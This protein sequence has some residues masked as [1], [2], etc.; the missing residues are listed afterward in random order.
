MGHQIE[1]FASVPE[2]AVR[3]WLDRLNGFY[4]SDPGEVPFSWEGDLRSGGAFWAHMTPKACNFSLA[5]NYS[6]L[7]HSDA[8]TVEAARQ[9]ETEFWAEFGPIPLLRVDEYMVGEWYRAVGRE[10]AEFEQPVDEL[11]AWLGSHDSH[12]HWLAPG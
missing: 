5:V 2:P 10:W 11:R 4:C 3:G 12:W 6:G 1:Y 9:F 7:F 8:N